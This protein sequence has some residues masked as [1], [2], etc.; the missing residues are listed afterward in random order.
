MNILTKKQAIQLLSG[1]LAT[2]EIS[3]KAQKFPVRS[4]NNINTFARGVIYQAA[5]EAKDA[6]NNLIITLETYGEDPNAKGL[7]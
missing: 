7:I 2:K 5:E 3:S 1:M 6:I 4:E